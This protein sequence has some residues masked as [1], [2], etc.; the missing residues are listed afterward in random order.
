MEQ[1]R[2]DREVEHEVA[3]SMKRSAEEENNT[4]LLHSTHT[5]IQAPGASLKRLDVVQERKR[6]NV[7]ELQKQAVAE[8]A[9]LADT[10]RDVVGREWDEVM[11]T[12]AQ[13]EERRQQQA[14]GEAVRK[15]QMGGFPHRPCGTPAAVA[16]SSTAGQVVRPSVTTSLTETGTRMICL[17][18]TSPSGSTSTIF[19]VNRGRAQL[20]SSERE[21]LMEVRELRQKLANRARKEDSCAS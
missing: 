7:T 11:N 5:N 8:E 2:L 20:D 19:S 13:L 15:T 14:S 18:S 6:G 10:M 1:E 21:L 12:R 17:N 16:G 3:M 9:G 4:D